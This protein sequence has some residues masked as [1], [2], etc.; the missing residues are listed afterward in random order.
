MFS[1]LSMQQVWGTASCGRGS[2]LRVRRAQDRPGFE[3]PAPP[4]DYSVAR[5]DF[6]VP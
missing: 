5:A 4:L 2:G 6:S 1:L 3:I